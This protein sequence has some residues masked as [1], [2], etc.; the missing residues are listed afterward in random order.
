M[1]IKKRSL[2][3]D[4][5]VTD[6]KSTPDQTL[7][8][9]HLCLYTDGG[10]RPSRGIGGWGIHGYFFKKEKPKQGSGC[11]KAKLTERGYTTDKKVTEITPIHYVDGSGSLIPET[12]NNLAELQAAIVALELAI[13]HN[14]LSIHLIL[15]ST[16]VLKG[17]FEYLDGW[18]QSGWVKSDGG[19]V[20]NVEH[21]KRLGDLKE[22]LEK[23]GVEVSASKVEGHSGDLGNDLADSHATRGIVAGRKG[24]AYSN[25][26]IKEAK[27]YWSTKPVYNRLFS[28]NNWYFNTNRPAP[29]SEDGRHIYHL[30][31]HGTED[32]FL[33]KPISDASFGILFTQPE[34]VLEE[35]RSYQNELDETTFNSVIIGSL[36]NI[37]KYDTYNDILTNGSR[38]LHAP[39]RK[40]DIYTAGDT[41][42]TKDLK[43]AKL[44]INT[45]DKLAILETVLEQFL[46]GPDKHGLSV[47]DITDILYEDVIKGKNIHRKVSDVLSPGTNAIRVDVKHSVKGT[48][49]TCPLTLTVG[50]DIPNRNTFS[51]VA[52][53]K[54]RVYVVTWKESM[55]AFRYATIIHTEDTTGIWSGLFSN[56]RLL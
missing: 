32:D 4:E 43:P 10:A 29:K 22:T 2:V 52:D 8:G 51:A 21:W 14:V 56:I 27:G 35:I 6:D 16:Y 25:I 19:D 36:G 18:K 41:Q 3:V 13:E 7:N 17:L 23:K 48:V 33:M 50:V 55:S 9:L 39:T 44:A 11:G 5:T 45:F 26:E 24:I 31:D 15:D 30:G 37:F 40:I 34:P 54:P 28:F 49:S 47:T 20:Q 12:T 38:F 1:E 46:D 53:L 42:L